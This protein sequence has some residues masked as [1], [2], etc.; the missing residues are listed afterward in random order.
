M[1][2]IKKYKGKDHLL[3]ILD[4]GAKESSFRRTLGDYLKRIGPTEMKKNKKN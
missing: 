4:D 2:I 3:C 1:E